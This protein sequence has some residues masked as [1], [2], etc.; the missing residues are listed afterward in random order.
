MN[1]TKT[2]KQV[3]FHHDVFLSHLLRFESVTKCSLSGKKALG[4][5]LVKKKQQKLI[6]F[7]YLSETCTNLPRDA[8][9]GIGMIVPQYDI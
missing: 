4:I 9:L 1:H 8:F 6:L 2:G 3:C 7:K 5:I